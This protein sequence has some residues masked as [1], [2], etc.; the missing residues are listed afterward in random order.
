ML[1]QQKYI[2]VEPVARGKSAL[3]HYWISRCFDDEVRR[4]NE[5]VLRR[6]TSCELG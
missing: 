5:K 6:N 4:E 2:S 3:F 1:F